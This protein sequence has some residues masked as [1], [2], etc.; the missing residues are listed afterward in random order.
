MIYSPEKYKR[1]LPNINQELM[2][3]NG[4]LDDKDAELSL[5]K[6]LR[7]NVGFTT[8]LVS[9][10]HLES[11]QEIILKGFLNRN[12]SMAVLGR[13]GGKSFL[14][15]IFIFLQCLFEPNSK[16]LI[17]GP[18][19]RTA[20]NI[21]TELDKIVKQKEAK[22]L[23][24]SFGAQSKR[25]DMFEWEINGGLIRAIPLNGEKVRGFRANILVLDEF[26]LLSQHIVDTVLMPF[27]TV[28]Q[29][30]GDIIK[31]RSIE[32]SLIKKGR[33][34]EKERFQFPNTSKMIALSSASF[35][36]ENLYEVYSRWMKKIYQ[37]KK[38]DDEDLKE[39]NMEHRLSAKYFIAQMGYEAIPEHLWD[40]SIIQEARSGG[41]NNASFLREYCA[42]FVDGSDSYFSAKAMKEL[43]IED[44]EYPCIQLS[45]K[46]NSKYIFSIDPCFSNDPASDHFS[47]SVLLL[48]MEKRVPTLVHNYA[49]AG[50]N[51]EDHH[52]YIYY[53]YKS[54]DPEMIIIDSTGGGGQFL[55]GLN[56]SVLFKENKVELR[57]I[58]F[59]SIADGENWKKT[60][61][62]SKQKYNKTMGAICI[63]QTFGSTFLRKANEY[64]KGCIDYKKI[65]FASRITPNE[66][67]YKEICNSGLDIS[68]TGYESLIDFIDFQDRWI[69]ETKNQCA[70]I[71]V[72]SSPNGNQTFDLPNHLAKDKRPNRAR[73]DSY[74][75]L[76]LAN[77]AHKV[78]FDVIDYK[79]E[80]ENTLPEPI[81]I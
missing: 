56:G 38:E 69:N 55:E 57:D 77:W 61:I 29:N 37:S 63:N 25:P 67:E 28:P 51:L 34:S 24:D 71:E 46:K 76:L 36:F 81:I 12:Y 53:L 48:D 1:N 15:G 17:A 79:M 58:E 39:M 14:A 62:E 33:M 5:A 11:Y 73:K 49:Y 7:A 10:I 72:K 52:K 44:G 64:L 8:E 27:L 75:T 45:G 66:S 6:F 20:R 19:F 4:Y 13:G 41:A 68:L 3:M 60:L 31:I 22:L 9:G 43:T 23:A 35:T 47:I 65:K 50:K 42:R 59:D 30:I 80:K 26:L 78:Y 18:T 16:I 21:F 54:F 40:P 32:D 74:T 70:I 2:Q